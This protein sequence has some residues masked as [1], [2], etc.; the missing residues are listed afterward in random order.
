MSNV[1]IIRIPILP[2][3]LVNAHL[4]F[5]ETGAVLVDAGLPDSEKR[6]LRVLNRMGLTFKSIRLIVITHAHIDHAG[7]ALR[8]KQLTGAPIVAHEGDLPYYRRQRPMTYCA[9]GWFGRLF[10]K[11]GLM[12]APFDAF[13]P[14][15][16]LSGDQ[17][18]KL[19]EWGIKGVIRPTPGHTEGSLS[20]ELEDRQ[21]LVGDLLASGILLGG[22]LLTER[23]KKPPFEDDPVR[24]AESLERMVDIGGDLFF[25][26][27]G[28]PLQ[29]AQVKRHIR[30][31]R[32]R[33]P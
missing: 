22:I 1:Q 9:T 2:L 15:I 19:D 14:D 25:M 33:R 27:H 3:G 24:V 11:T 28:G 20:V 18:L 16:L 29:A 7:N 17:V 6:I 10:L 23:P 30:S 21:M 12:H 26:G 32:E 13:E 31:L 4:I 8:L 5:D